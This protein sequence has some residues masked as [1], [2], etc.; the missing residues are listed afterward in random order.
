MGDCCKVN[1][2]AYNLSR[3]TTL[4][5]PI[6]ANNVMSQPYVSLVGDMHISTPNGNLD[7]TF[8]L[9]QF[10]LSGLTTTYRDRASY[11]CDDNAIYRRPAVP[12]SLLSASNVMYEL[13]SHVGEG[14]EYVIG[15]SVMSADLTTVSAELEF[16]DIGAITV[17]NNLLKPCCGAESDFTVMRGYE[18]L[19][20]LVLLACV[21]N[22][23]YTVR[24]KAV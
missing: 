14:V 23:L 3:G 8:N 7:I 20:V 21:L 13:V 11:W 6:S 18:P 10:A 4:F 17:T 16:Y 1:C 15:L 22:W 12:I 2:G 19:K 24:P 9:S 5:P